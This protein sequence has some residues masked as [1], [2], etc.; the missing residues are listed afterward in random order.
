MSIV[1]PLS[2]TVCHR[3]LKLVP[4][5]DI[6]WVEGQG[7]YS[8]IH[9]QNGTFLKVAIPISSMASRLPELIRAHRWHLINLAHVRSLNRLPNALVLTTG[10]LLPV[11]RRRWLDVHRRY[12]TYRSTSLTN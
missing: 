11:A 2:R 6:V 12:L 4:L 3:P 1:S 8:L 9:F 7:P 10:E 5:A